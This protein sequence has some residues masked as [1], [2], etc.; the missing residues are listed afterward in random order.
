MYR[1]ST[2]NRPEFITPPPDSSEILLNE[3]NFM[4]KEIY[5]M[6]NLRMNTDVNTYN[7]SAVARKI[8]NQQYYQSIAELAQGLQEAEKLIYKIF[9]IY[10]GNNNIEEFNISYNKEYAILDTTEVLNNATTSLALGMTNEYN[11]EMRKQV[12]RAILADIDTNTL[13]D[14]IRS[15]DESKDSENPLE[16][17]ASVVQPTRS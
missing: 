3:I 9:N 10:M 8:E 11:K 17:E 1:A 13:N 7:V 6:A 16:S 12:A 15:I 14:I 4:V 2:G 5:R